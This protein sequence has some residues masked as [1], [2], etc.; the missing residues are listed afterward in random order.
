MTLVAC[1]GEQS[2]EPP[3]HSAAGDLRAFPARAGAKWVAALR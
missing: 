2:G 1:I 3:P